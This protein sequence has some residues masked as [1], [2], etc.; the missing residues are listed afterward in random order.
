MPGG[1]DTGTDTA[2]AGIEPDADLDAVA[3]RM[4][5]AL[6]RIARHLDAAKPVRPPAELA[7]R[8]DRLIT[9]LRDVL[10]GQPGVSQE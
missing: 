10:G 2:R 9:R 1:T 7:A 6:E 8:L 4:E 3:D 5:A